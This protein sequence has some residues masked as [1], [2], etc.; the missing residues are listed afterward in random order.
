[1]HHR[2]LVLALRHFRRCMDAQAKGH[3]LT[4]AHEALKTGRALLLFALR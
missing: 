2:A 3:R 1:M 4:A